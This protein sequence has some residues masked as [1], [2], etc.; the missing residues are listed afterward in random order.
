MS[1]SNIRRYQNSVKSWPIPPLTHFYSQ[2]HI[3]DGSFPKTGSHQRAIHILKVQNKF[4]VVANKGIQ[5]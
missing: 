4:V 5:V 1:I 2:K 3:Q